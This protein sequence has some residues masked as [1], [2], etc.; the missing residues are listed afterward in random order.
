MRARTAELRDTLGQLE[1]SVHQLRS[2]QQ[3]VVQHERMS[4]L[5]SMAAGLAHDFNNALSLILGYGELL[6]GELTDGPNRQHTH[7]FLSTI[8][9][10]AQDAAKVF[11]RLRGFYRTADDDQMFEPLDLNALIEQAVA[12][13]RPRWHGQA[14]GEGV[15]IDVRTDLSAELPALFA[16]GSEM[17][18]MLTNLIFNA[19][20]AMPS[21]GGSI[22][23]STR[24]TRHADDDE[25]SIVVTV[26]DTGAGM[27]E[28]TRRRCLEP[29]FTT[30]GD[31]GTGLGLAMV[32]GTMK[33]LDGEIELES[34]PGDGTVFRFTLP[35][36]TSLAVAP[37]AAASVGS[38][39]W[40][41]L[42][43]DD[44][45][46]FLNALHGYLARG[47]LEVDTARG[48]VEAIE[49]FRARPYD[50]IITDKAMPGITGEELAQTLKGFAPPHA[51]DHAD[52]LQP[53]GGAGRERGDRPGD[54]QARHSRRFARCDREGDGESPAVAIAREAQAAAVLGG[55]DGMRKPGKLVK[56]DASASI[57]HL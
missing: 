54:P 40:S 12:L 24:L 14:L 32:Y 2:T 26:A 9:T 57:P 49:K 29:F 5:G 17:R 4:A 25:E 48:A 43:V 38:V 33:R 53:V 31:R 16:D 34:A 15:T 42:I 10:A 45:L 35:V 8:I 56:P 20:D 30:K 27:T 50:L 41:I 7:E 23:L 3:Q 19:V 28:E 13:T 46:D 36:R 44:E 21:P 18:E 51:G 47:G 6:L 37:E 39:P 22:R 11:D 52:G 55:A 1:E